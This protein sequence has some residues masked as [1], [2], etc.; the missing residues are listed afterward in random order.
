MDYVL[1]DHGFK[2]LCAELSVQECG[3]VL[4]RR[5]CSISLA[6]VSVFGNAV[7]VQSSA[8]HGNVVGDAWLCKS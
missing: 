1:F 5:C 8:G 2:Q 4:R 6:F 3:A 7:Q